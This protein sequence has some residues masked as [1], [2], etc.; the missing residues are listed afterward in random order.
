LTNI[1][2]SRDEL[3][4]SVGYAQPDPVQVELEPVS[5]DWL[6]NLGIVRNTPKTL[7]RT[8]EEVEPL[9]NTNMFKAT[10]LVPV[11]GNIPLETT[12]EDRPGTVEVR[13]SRKRGA[14]D[15]EPLERVQ[16]F[17]RV[18]NHQ[19][20]LPEDSARPRPVQGAMELE[21]EDFQKN[22][23]SRSTLKTLN[24]VSEEME[25]LESVNAVKRARINR[26]KHQS[27]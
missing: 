3:P 16:T 5:E 7:K 2:I 4:W 22:V 10:K 23:G 27:P 13:N 18:C 25:S 6:K 1:S 11:D 21:S 26:Y 9:G 14:E 19:N 24:R 8:A 12:T 15:S 17:K 20:A